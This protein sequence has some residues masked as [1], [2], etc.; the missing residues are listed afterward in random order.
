V[1]KNDLVPTYFDGED[2]SRPSS[3][4]KSRSE[5]KERRKAG[6]L[7]GGYVSNGAI[8]IIFRPFSAKPEADR[9]RL[10]ASGNM[11]DAWIQM[12]SG[13]AGPMVLQMPPLEIP[14]MQ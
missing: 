1:S 4:L 12:Q 13:Y 7:H 6:L 8:F 14:A 3:E 9:E 2:R 11:S 5:I 10:I